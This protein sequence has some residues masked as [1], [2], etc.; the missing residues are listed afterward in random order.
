VDGKGWAS[1]VNLVPSYPYQSFE[2]E[3]RMDEV[4]QETIP[5]VPSPPALLTGFLHY[6]RVTMVVQLVIA[7]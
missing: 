7:K 4:N 2:P 3:A 6:R 1:E 5:P